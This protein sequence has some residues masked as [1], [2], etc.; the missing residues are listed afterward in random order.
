MK[1]IIQNSIFILFLPLLFISCSPEEV[2]NITAANYNAQVVKSF[3]YDSDMVGEWKLQAMVA[4]KD[5]DLDGDGELNN[6]LLNET[7]CF[8]NMSY[9]F[10]GN[11]TFTIVNA[12][13][14]LKAQNE[15]D[16]FKCQSAT[17]ISGKWSIK[18]DML[19]L[20]IKKNNQEYTEQKHLIYTKDQFFIEINQYE[21]QD[22]INDKGNSSAAGLSVVALEFKRISK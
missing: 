20:Y 22:Y 17:T 12:T 16:E 11:K 5:I 13:L 19:T 6:D 7:S 21:S 10:R 8:E 15:K 18:D 9:T 1:K 14:E 4:N 2:E 3:I